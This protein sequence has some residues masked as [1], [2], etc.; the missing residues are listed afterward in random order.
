MTNFEKWFIKRVLKREVVQSHT[1][2]QNIKNLYCM[3]RE[4]VENEFAEDNIPTTNA[5]LKEQFEA[6]QK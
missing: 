6:T 4:A 2:A 3:I 1:H 5:F